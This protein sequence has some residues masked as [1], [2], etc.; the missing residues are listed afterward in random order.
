MTHSNRFIRLQQ[1]INRPGRVPALVGLLFIVVI[2]LPTNCRHK[3]SE[4]ATDLASIDSSPYHNDMA[5]FLAGMPVSADSQPG[6]LTKSAAWQRHRSA[7]DGFWKAVEH[8]HL[9]LIQPWQK[10]HLADLTAGRTALYLLSGADFLNLASFFPDSQRYVMLALEASD[11]LPDPRKLT[12]AE[13]TRSLEAIRSVTGNIGARNYFMS[14]SMNRYLNG[15]FSFRGTT[16]VILIF[17]ARLGFQIHSIE[18]IVLQDDGTIRPATLQENPVGSRIRVYRP[19]DTQLREIVYLQ[20]RLSDANVSPQSKSGRYLH[21]LG[22][23]NV[24]LKSAVYLLHMQ[25]FT[26]VRDFVLQQAA[27]IVQDDSGVPYSFLKN[28]DWQVRL[29]GSYQAP[30]RLK[31]TGYYPQPELAAD[32]KQTATPL[33][34][35]YGYGTL[36]PDGQSNLLI[37]QRLTQ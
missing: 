3:I 14:A 29:Y 24:M 30:V 33:A 9:D 35:Q 32:Y 31:G 23:V 36:R 5:R 8:Q 26:G 2:L 27:L 25:Q 12:N 17:A 22:P 37:A 20:V 1:P 4:N 18:S 10:E 19:G 15:N 34:F 11:R 6:S 13:I 7:M 28:K 16:P 21:S